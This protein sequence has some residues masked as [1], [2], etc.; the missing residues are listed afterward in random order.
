MVGL[1]VQIA[2]CSRRVDGGGYSEAPEI[3]KLAKMVILQD[4]AKCT[5]GNCRKDLRFHHQ[6]GGNFFE[7]FVELFRADENKLIRIPVKSACLLD[8]D[9][10]KEDAPT[11][12]S[13]AVGKTQLRTRSEVAGR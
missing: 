6:L 12:Q 4:A 11:P 13:P 8:N 7:H 3:P 10:E 9:P 1:P 5:Q 2:L